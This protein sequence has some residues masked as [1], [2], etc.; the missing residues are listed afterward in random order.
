MLRTLVSLALLFLI[1]FS[2]L[3]APAYS[4]SVRESGPLAA[5]SGRSNPPVQD[6]DRVTIGSFTV[7]RNS[8]ETDFGIIDL[9]Q[10]QYN[11]DFGRT[12]FYGSGNVAALSKSAQVVSIGG[13]AQNDQPLLG[14]AISKS[15]LPSNLGFSYSVDSPL[16]FDFE[17]NDVAP[18]GRLSGSSIIGSDNVAEQYGV[19]G[20]GVTVAIVDMGTDFSNPDMMNSLAR[21][22]D[23]VPIMLDADAQGIVLTR[24]TYIAKIDKATGKML[25]AGYTPE[26]KLPENMTS[27]VYVNETGT[28]L[29]KTSHGDI[30]VYNTLYPYFGEP[31][32]NATARVDWKIGHSQTDYIRSASGIYRFGVIFQ[33]QLHFGTL[34]FPLVPVLVVDS[35]EP[36]VYDTIIPDMYSAWYFY[37]RNDLAR[38]AE[39]E[40]DVEHLFPEP[41]FDFTDDVPIK[42]SDGNE[43]LVYDYNK[44]GFPDFSAGT[45]GARVVDLWQVASNNTEPKLGEETGYGG[46]VVAD[47]LEPQD[48]AGDYFGLMYDLQGHGTSTAA[49][50]SSEGR[51]QYDIYGNGT[52]YPLAGIAPGAKIIPVKALWAG[53]SLYGWLYAAGFDL[54]TDG[55]W[56]YSGD[57]RADIISN[58]WGVSSFPLLQ[59]GPGY[60]II[61][62]LSSM[63]VVPGL[64][65]EDYPGV[66]MVNSLGNN[67]LGYGT[68]GSPNISPLAISVGATTNNVHVGYNGFQN[69][70]RFGSTPR[71]FDD[72]ADFSSRGPGLVGD[73]KP[74]LMA[75][76]SYAFTPT[77]VNLKNLG[78]TPDDPNND[79]AFVLFGGTSMAAP[80]VAGTAALVISD[81]KA[82]DRT[83]DPFEVKTMLMSSAV[84]LKNDPF[85]QGSGRVDALGALDL[86]RGEAGRISAYTEDTVPNILSTMSDAIYGYREVL[87]IIGTAQNNTSQKPEEKFRDS[88]WF[89]GYIEQGES[90]S[91]EIVVEN[92]TSEEIDVHVSAMTEKLVARYQIHNSTRPLEKD[93]VHNS[94]KFGYIPNYYGLD[95]IG[96]IPDDA[97]LMV[98]RINFQFED[99]MNMTEIYG[100]HLRIASLYAYDWADED[101]DGK[102]SYTETSM[103][104]RGGSWGTIQEL[105]IGDPAERF[106]NTP[107]IGVYPV[108]SIFSFWRGDRQINSTAM[109]FT[110]TVEYY[111]RESAPAVTL[112]GSSNSHASLAI[113][114]EGK[115]TLTAVVNVDQEALPGVYQ[116]SIIITPDNKKSRPVLIPVS[117]VVTTG[118]VP[119]D[120]PVVIKPDIQEEKDLGLRPIGYVGG[121]FDM[122]SR[123]PAGDWRTYYFKVE[124]PTITSMSLKISWPHNSTSIN[125]MAFGPDGRMAASSVP[126][127]VFE[128]FVGWPS[129]DWLGTT[130][131]SEGGAFYF[132]QNAGDNS[133]LMHV[134]IKSTG[135]YT[136]LLHNTLF[137]GNNLYEP[138][139]VE[140]KFSTILPDD[141]P[142]VIKVRLPKYIGAD[143]YTI[144]VTIIDENLADYKYVIDLGEPVRPEIAKDKSF[145]I[146]I[147]GSEFTEGIHRLRVDSTDSVGY[148]S[149]FASTFEVDKTPPSIDV[150]AQV[151]NRTMQVEDRIA[152][153]EGAAM[154]SWNVT[155]KNGVVQPLNVAVP[156]ATG[157]TIP[158]AASSS[159]NMTSLADGRYN[160]TINAQDVLGNAI[161][162]SVQVTVDR[163]APTASLAVY[164]EA[165][166]IKGTAKIALDVQDPNLASVLLLIDGD[167]VADVTGLGEYELDTTKLPDGKH[168]LI[169]A[170]TDIAGNEQTAS[171]SIV[172]S[173]MEPT[174]TSAGLSGLVIGLAAGAGAASVAVWLIARRKPQT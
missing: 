114:P 116:S 42:I 52:G 134:P 76:G 18:A 97:D 72:I 46:V 77:L 146:I 26:S 37:T 33:T 168:D 138:V 154:L 102:V 174:I 38:V 117:Y 145:E 109:N 142:P 144:P 69:I 54:G 25:D 78:S 99:F 49:T 43:F 133:T 92:P 127:G 135:I 84:D 4:L 7:D 16:Q 32:L 111:Q 62:F 51:Q 14:V 164:G 64:L 80:M 95:E 53:D 39:R 152:F 5:F 113:P 163:T 118:P 115:A 24:A 89:A 1:T 71:Y 22:K 13:Q 112:D 79:E 85:V 15:P 162:R 108:P 75:I 105:R 74:E 55:V 96:S 8:V 3:L 83:A 158:S 28:V 124:D 34:T 82:Q 29:L 73:P 155:D 171:S 12:L 10:L 44:D 128:T 91:T 81:M 70:T 139:N 2:A 21:D 157:I 60:D 88:R 35:K 159:I 131:F 121:L 50:I 58:S 6:T 67:G 87:D 48:P 30:P 125:A 173:N 27:Y 136:L 129:N 63:L 61:S 98:A 66:V 123:Y 106:Q 47:L 90:A 36:G 41:S 9:G 93:P 57:H 23:G 126:A 110:L 143:V 156:N 20:S 167:M 132:S 19:N 148:S 166:D 101:K 169:L 130:S 120:V 160:F 172:I 161:K 56:R 40:S 11:G 153:S 165:T 170:A 107:L 65:A 147:K 17:P 104:N 100:D 68:V 45:V 140:A 151:Q 59:Y 86:A 119:K 149:S 122:T 150:I 137:H 103:V 94:T 141:S 31:V